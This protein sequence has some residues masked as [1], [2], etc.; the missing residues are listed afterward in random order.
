M[1]SLSKKIS[2][3]IVGPGSSRVNT[4]TLEEQSRKVINQ[5]YEKGINEVT[6]KLYICVRHHYLYL[7]KYLV[8]GVEMKTNRW[9]ALNI[10]VNPIIKYSLLTWKFQHARSKEIQWNTISYTSDGYDVSIMSTQLDPEVDKRAKLDAQDGIIL[11][12]ARSLMTFLNKVTLG[13]MKVKKD[14]KKDDQEE[15]YKIN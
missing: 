4:E 7:S 15:D 13:N 8:R 14:D 9:V 6:V 3:F 5:Y 2:N 11:R 12:S 1:L 10:G